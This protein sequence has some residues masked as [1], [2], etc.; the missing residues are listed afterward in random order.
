MVV[1]TD[2][3][4][5]NTSKITTN[6]NKEANKVDNKPN[7]DNK[8]N[9]HKEEIIKIHKC[10]NKNHRMRKKSI[11]SS[12]NNKDKLKMKKRNI[13]TRIEIKVY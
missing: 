1:I 8:D 9:R 4:N 3:C 2:K 12:S 7:K 10:I 5:S 6:I 13:R 11:C